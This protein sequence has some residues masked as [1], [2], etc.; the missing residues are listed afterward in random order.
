MTVTFEASGTSEALPSILSYLLEHGHTIGSRQGEQTAEIT[1]PTI[2]LTE[3]LKREILIPAR[4]ASLPAQIAETMWVLAGRNDVEWLSHYLPRAADFSDDGISWRSGYG[5]RLRDFNGVD[6]LSAVVQTIRGDWSTRRAVVSLWS[7][8]VDSLPGKDTACNNWLHFLSRNGRLDLHVATRSNDAIWGWSGINAFEWSALLEIVAHLTGNMVGKVVYSISSLHI[9][10]KHWNRALDISKAVL[11]GDAS[12]SP[13][14][15]ISERLS[16]R[17]T[18]SLDDLIEEWFRAEEILRNG[19][20]Y[21]IDAFPEP[22]MRSWL[23]IIAWKWSED[24]AILEPL[25]GTRLHA[26]AMMSHDNYQ[27]RAKD[28]S[29][30]APSLQEALVQ[31]NLYLVER[32]SKVKVGDTVTVL[33]VSPIPDA[34]ESAFLRFVDALHREKDAVYGDSWK[35]RGEQISILSNIARKIDRLGEAGGGDTAADTVIDLMVYLVKYLLWMEDAFGLPVSRNDATHVGQVFE[36]MRTLDRE[37]NAWSG[38]RRTPDPV[39]DLKDWFD[40]LEGIVSEDPEGVNVRQRINVVGQM[41]PVSYRLAKSLWDA[42]NPAKRW[43][44]SGYGQ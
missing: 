15:C 29:N 24:E 12:P 30:V 2:V 25:A 42:E 44:N 16:E 43:L 8:E 20:T 32:P 19:G 4:R 21:D 26:A 10:E 34:T 37:N 35:K 23:R 40:Q 36:V 27:M 9:Y 38:V 3:P 28:P 1:H 14:F 6:Q 33:P 11:S 41:L 13:R 18:R 31:G 7:P 17:S 39:K 5:P 22:M